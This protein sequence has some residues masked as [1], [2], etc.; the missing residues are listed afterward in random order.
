MAPEAPYHPASRR[1]IAGAFRATAHA[2]VRLCLRGSIHPDTVSYAS[3]AASAL[4]CLCFLAARRHPWLLLLGPLFCY[5]RLWL[6]MLDGMVA[7]ASG[8]ASPHGELLNDLPDRLS[9]VLVFA[10]LAHSGYGTPFLAYWAAL[11]ALATAYVGTLGQAVT[12]RREYGGIMAKPWR[13]VMVHLGAWATFLCLRRAGG[14]P[15]WGGLPPLDWTCL[16]VVAG[17]LQTV[18]VR[19]ASILR[20]LA[21]KEAP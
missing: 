17:C 10:G 18:W 20:R 11:A 9:D 15:A 2:A 6:N 12:G 1:P 8:K 7:I 19:L 5:L 21:A 4:A 13:M 14:C 16:L 3:V